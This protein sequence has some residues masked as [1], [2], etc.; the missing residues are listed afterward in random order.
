MR[1][2]GDSLLEPAADCLDAQTL[3]AL[4]TL[5][6]DDRAKERLELLAREANEGQLGA[7]E[8]REYEW[9][10]ELGDMLATLRLRAERRVVS[11][12]Q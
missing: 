4:A 7:E 12:R 8:A 1:G 6:L 10:I 11:V 2:V 3:R 5:Q 9:F